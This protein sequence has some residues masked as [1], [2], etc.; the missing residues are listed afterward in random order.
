MN[1]IPPIPR[2]EFFK[3]FYAAEALNWPYFSWLRR[4]GAS[5]GHCSEA[6]SLFPQKVSILNEQSD[7][8]ECFWGI[9]AREEVCLCWVLFYNF[10]CLTPPLVFFFV[11]LF[12]AT[13]EKDMQDSSVPFTL[14]AG[15][16]SI[17]WSAFLSSLQFGRV[18]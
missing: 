17:F 3:R 18:D 2:H 5:K 15:M 4:C 16:L 1:D 7:T 10:V 12:R 13:S 8:R 6:L 9:Y 14:M 11:W